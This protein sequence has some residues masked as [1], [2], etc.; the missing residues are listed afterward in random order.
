MIGDSLSRKK[1][2]FIIA[3]VFVVVFVAFFIFR[4][5]ILR[6]AIH[7]V[8]SRLRDHQVEVHF[9]NAHFKGF[10]TVYFQGIYMQTDSGNGHLEIKALTIRPKIFPLFAQKIRI[11]RLSCESIALR[12][13]FTDSVIQEQTPVTHDTVGILDDLKGRNFADFLYK[14][15]RRFFNYIP[16]KVLIEHTDLRFKYRGRSTA[17]NLE[18]FR[19]THGNVSAQLK[20]SGDSLYS[21]IPLS[22]RMDRAASVLEIHMMNSDT[23][24]LPIPLLKDKYGVETG[25]GSFDFMV[26]LAEKNR[27]LLNPTGSFSITGFE[28]KAKRLSSESI[29]IGKFASSFKLNI[30]AH[31]FEIDSSSNASLNQIAFNPY[32]RF[33]SDKGPQITFKII[34]LTWKADDFFSSLPKGMFTSLSGIKTTGQLHF[35]LSFSVDMDHPDSLQFNTLLTGENFAITGYGTDDYRMINGSFMHRVYERDR[36]VA[37]FLVGPENPDFVPLEEIS[38]FARA[39]VMTSEDGSFYYHNGF[40]QDAFREAIATNIKEKRFARGGS[41]I[42]MQLVK[43]IFLTRNK[44]LA[45][46][47]EEAI[48]VWLIENKNLVAKQRMYEVYLNMIEWGPGIYGINQASHFYFNKPPQNI[49]FGEAVYLASI[50]PHPKWFKY[51]FVTNGVPRNFYGNYFKRMKELMV[52]KKFIAPEDTFGTKPIITLTGPA[53]QFFIAPDTAIVDTASIHELEILP[54]F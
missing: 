31:Y 54:V 23:F 26:N 8:E 12:Y 46:K 15:S 34:P 1:V 21:E 29:R 30:G 37:S 48:I 33:Q 5:V 40:N 43:N 47:I 3:G 17:I 45:R 19:L 16:S 51:T 20:V 36:L 10:R 13:Y 27:H 11:S 53:A 24:L 18:S 41:T 9:D 44:T 6:K 7:E 52:R 50:V 49:N 38:I 42:T 22:G 39:A 32:F 25:F 14:N 4:G 35:F 2:L 28:L